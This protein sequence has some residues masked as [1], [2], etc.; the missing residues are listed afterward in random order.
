VNHS[1]RWYLNVL[2]EPWQL[3]QN[4]DLFFLMLCFKVLV[5]PA[6][7]NSHNTAQN[8]YG[9]GFL[10]IPDK[11]ESYFYSLINKA[12]AFFKILRFILSRLFSLRRRFISSFP[13]YHIFF[14]RKGLAGVGFKML[15]LMSQTTMV[16][17]KGSL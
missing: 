14:A 9:I 6:S 12:V 7:T 11:I 4:P 8:G 5:I 15:F 13:L 2:G 1:Y 10:L 3:T 17:P 16:D